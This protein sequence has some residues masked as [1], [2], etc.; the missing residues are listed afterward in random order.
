MTILIPS[1]EP[2]ERLLHLVDRIMELSD[3][4]IVVVDDG[5]GESYHYI[6]NVLETS[7]CTVLHHDINRGKGGALKT[8]FQ[9]LKDIGEQGNIVCADSDGQHLPEDIMRISQA[10]DEPGRHLVLGSRQFSGKVPLRSRFGNTLTRMVYSFTTGIKIHD[11]QTGLRGFPAH[12][13]D[14]LCQIP[15]ERFE[16]EM[17]MLLRAHKDGYVIDELFINTIYLEHNKSSHFRPLTDS[18]SVYLPILLFSASSFLS[19][20]LDFVLLLL[21]QYF[22]G[23]LFIAVL[24]SRICSSTFNFT[25]NRRYVFSTSQDSTLSTSLTKYFTLALVVLLLNY[26]VLF[27]YHE[28]IGMPL[29]LAKLLT[30][31]SIFLISYWAQRRYVY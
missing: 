21:I 14:W 30:E 23:N 12:M 25:M 28:Q 24:L 20:I 16:Y 31:G 15:G 17:N 13:L 1:Y 26:G 22:I 2:D 3:V 27:M 6:F 9:Y 29:I 19:G 7:G 8:G 4:D 18:I 11:T 5:S 10:L